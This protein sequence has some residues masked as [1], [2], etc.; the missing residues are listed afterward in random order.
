MDT[1]H[2]PTGNPWGLKPLLD[3]GVLAHER[4]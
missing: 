1:E 4:R 2:R 3:V